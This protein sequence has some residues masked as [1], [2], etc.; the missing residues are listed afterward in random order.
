MASAKQD[1]DTELRTNLC[2]MNETFDAIIR[3]ANI[4]PPE[5]PAVDLTTSQDFHSMGE[6][7]LGKLSAIE[8]CC[9]IAAASTQK[10]YDARTIRDKIAVKRRQLAELESENAALIETAKRQE[11]ALRQATQ[12]TDGNVDAQQN[13]LKLRSQLQA[14]QKEIKVLEDKRHGLLSENR[15]LKGQLNNAQKVAGRSNGAE[16]PSASEAELAASIEELEERQRQLEGRKQRE[17]E[18]YQRKMGQLKGQKEEL[19]A[20]K[21]ELEQILREKQKELEL[22]HQQKSKLRPKLA[23]K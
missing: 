9:D 15:K 12:G 10:K 23:K 21:A 6:M 4:P 2:L 17:Q 5:L 7:L 19:S 13:V 11:K 16:G 1:L 22:I 20:R 8:K 14:A 18:A 3:E